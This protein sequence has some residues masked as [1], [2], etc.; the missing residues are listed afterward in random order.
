MRLAVIGVGRWGRHFAR[1]F[2]HHPAI[3]LVALVDHQ[4]SRLQTVA[5]ELQLPTTVRLENDFEQLIRST[6]LDAVVIA[7]PVTSHFG[8]IQMA[9][10]QGLHVLAEKPL[11]LLPSDCLALTQLAR[12]QGVQLFVDHTYGFH[13]AVQRGAGAGAIA[14]LGTLRYGY[15]TRSH[16]GPVR[17]DV[18]V[19]WDLAI[20]DLAIFNCWLGQ[21][22]QQVQ[23]QGQSWLQA[24]IADVVWATLIYSDGF[25]ATCHWSWDNPDKQRRLG[26]V[27]DRGTLL[28][29]E[30]NITAPLQIYWGESCQ[31]ES[32]SFAPKNL[33]SEVLTFPAQEPLQNVCDRFIESIQTGQT[34]MIA[35][36]QIATGLVEVLQALTR[37]LQAGGVVQTIAS[38]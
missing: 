11:T 8:L 16:L 37:S 36:G 23:A 35:S 32:G 38:Q 25:R 9:L 20:H 2:A 18:D 29:D 12:A 28:L 17:Q 10:R 30:M 27:G 24:G 3:E 4:R 1:L 22:P 15:A 14:D 19:L 21:R 26:V 6:E 7:T 13:P 5:T 31:N 34:P 33:H